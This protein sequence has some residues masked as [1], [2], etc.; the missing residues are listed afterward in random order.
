MPLQVAVK[1]RITDAAILNMAKRGRCEGQK[2]ETRV[3][4]NANEVRG[5]LIVGTEISMIL[6]SN[7]GLPLGKSNGDCC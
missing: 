6:E 3:G 2:E 4:R 1:H 7:S 5:E